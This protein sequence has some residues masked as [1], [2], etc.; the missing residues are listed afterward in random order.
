MAEQNQQPR[1]GSV[2]DFRLE[3]EK[4]ARRK[5]M[6][7]VRRVAIPV[8]ILTVLLGYVS[9]VFGSSLAVAEDL[10]DSARIALS[11]AA[12]YPVQTGIAE[13]YQLQEMSGGFVALGEENCVLYS[14]GGNRLR[15]IQPGYA[16]PAISVGRHRFVIYNRSGTELRVESRT[17]TLYTKSFSGGILL[18]EMSHGGVLAVATGSSRYVAELN[19]Y[20]S[21]MENMLTWQMVESEGTPV[22]LAFSDDDSRLAV[23]TLTASGG[24]LMSN[25]YLLNTKKAGE[26]LLASVYDAVPLGV[27]WRSS[28]EVLVLYDTHAAVYNTSNGAEKYRFDYG[29]DTL[30][31]WSAEGNG[32]A[33]L[34]ENGAASRMVLLEKD[35]DA[36][37]DQNTSRAN[38]LTLTRTAVYVLT[39]TAVECYSTG[40]EY[41]W[42]EQRD[43][44]PLAVLDTKRLLLFEGNTALELQPS[45]DGEE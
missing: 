27:V 31:G 32:L 39:D 36:K 6:R 24:R 30:I 23:A 5:K 33:L 14:A 37:S 29:G 43:V 8:L 26:T 9:G 38:A 35:L 17:Q 45:D 41:Q 7:A 1:A 2:R 40:G 11:P 25:L 4:L 10:V 22:R 44:K 15:S 42:S 12:G 3:S 20:S 18:A 13:L 19:V 21:L 16:R 28:S 34:F